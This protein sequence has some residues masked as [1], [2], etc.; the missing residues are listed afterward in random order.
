MI[1][2][3]AIG[4]INNNMQFIGLIILI[5]IIC[6]VFLYYIKISNEKHSEI[7][8]KYNTGGS[9]IRAP[10]LNTNG[11]GPELQK[12]LDYHKDTRYP[13]SNDIKVSTATL[14]PCQIHFNDDGTS[15]YIYEDGWMEF[16]T[17]ISND[18]DTGN[19]NDGVDNKGLVYNVPYKKFGQDNNNMSDF[20]NF[21][22]TTKCFKKKEPF[23][24]SLN[25]YKY[26]SNDL[27]K[28]R[29][30]TYI[31]INV[32]ENNKYD[33]KL[34]MQMNFDKKPS[35]APVG[36]YKDD[37]LNSICSYNYN[38][39]LTLGNMKL[40]R[41]TII[42]KTERNEN[43]N[44]S[45]I[46]G[47]HYITIK[48]DNNSDFIVSDDNE[49]K[50]ALPE[51][52]V[53]N[54]S[55]Y[56]INN[57][58][59]R[60][61][62]KKNQVTGDA[63]NGINVKIYKFNRNLDCNDTIRSYETSDTRFKSEDL[64]NV[65][66]YVSEI[67][68]NGNQ[69]PSDISISNVKEII[70]YDKASGRVI[71]GMS[72]EVLEKSLNLVIKES[73]DDKDSILQAIY[74][75]ICKLIAYS[76][77]QLVKDVVTLINNNGIQVAKKKSFIESFDTF[78]K[79]ISLY[80]QNVFDDVRKKQLFDEIAKTKLI[81]N[82][83]IYSYK[84]KS[85]PQIT[86]N[87]IP[88]DLENAGYDIKIYTI[89][90]ADKTFTVNENIVCDILIVAGGG[91]GGR[92]RHP[93]GRAGGGGGAG[94]L[95]YMQNH[96]LSKG[97]YTITVG[98]GGNIDVGG[99][100]RGE[101]FDGGSSSFGSFVATGGGGGG[102]TFQD[103]HYT[104]GRAGGSGGGAGAGAAEH[105][106]T[107][108]GGSGVSRQGFDG[109]GNRAGSYWGGAGAG[110]GGAGGN[111]D[112]WQNVNWNHEAGKG[113]VG[114]SINITG[115]AV[116]YA[117]GGDGGH[118][119]GANTPINGAANTGNGGDGS[120]FKPAGR[121][122][123][124][125]VIVRY[126]KT[127]RIINDVKGEFI[128][129]TKHQAVSYK[130][131]LYFK[132]FNGY[133]N[134]NLRFT[135]DSNGNGRQPD[136][137]T[138]NGINSGIV[139][140]ISNL[141]EGTNNSISAENTGGRWDSYTVEWQ[142]YF[143]AQK[144][145]TYHFH[146]ASDDASHLWIGE[147]AYT[148]ESNKLTVNNGGLHGRHGVS[149]SIYLTS[150]IYYPMRIL[151][152]ENYGHDNMSVYFHP[153]G[154]NW[155]TNGR[156]WY[157]HVQ[158]N[159]EINRDI[160]VN[161]NNANSFPKL[162]MKDKDVDVKIN[163]SSNLKLL[164][165]R[166]YIIATISNKTNI[167]SDH[168]NPIR[169]FLHSGGAENQTVHTIFFEKDTI[170]DILIVAGGGGGGM[171][172]GG[173]G[174][175]GGVIELLNY[176][177]KA[178][179]YN[180]NIGRGGKGAPAAGTSG[181]PSSHQYTI[182][183]TQGSNSSF[184]TIT[185]IG[186]GF[187]G[188]SY[189][190][191]TLGGRGGNGGSGGGTSGYFYS[192]QPDRAGKGTSGQGNNGGYSAGA[193]Y[194]AGG[195]GAGQVGGGPST[196]DGGAR[197][198]NGKESNILGTPYYWGGGGGGSSWSVSGGDGGLGGGG[199]GTG[200]YYSSRI[201]Q[202]GAGYINNGSPGGGNSRPRSGWGYASGGNGGAHT[203]GGGGGGPHYNAENKGG[204]GGSG[205]VIIKLKGESIYETAKSDNL[206]ISYDIIDENAINLKNARDNSVVIEDNEYYISPN[207]P[208]AINVYN[209]GR[210]T[211]SE[212]Y[213]K[214]F[215]VIYSLSVG[216]ITFEKGQNGGVI[217]TSD[218]E[219]KINKY[220]SASS[221]IKVSVILVLFYKNVIG[222][223][224]MRLTGYS[225]VF[226]YNT[227]SNPNKKD[228]S[229]FNISQDFSEYLAKFIQFKDSEINKIFG[230]DTY[231][232]DVQAKINNRTSVTIIENGSLQ[233]NG[234]KNDITKEKLEK[235]QI[236]YNNVKVFNA[237]SS[238]RR[239]K[240]TINSNKKI[241][242]IIPAFKTDIVS[243]E[244]PK[245]KHPLSYSSTYNIQPISNNYIYFRYPNQ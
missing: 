28:Y 42:P 56:T 117:K 165:N 15:K 72:S 85:V 137:Q 214:K 128:I 110:G 194:G 106:G 39:D 245:N 199:G 207:N 87:K 210:K 143:Y 46:S 7:I 150:G 12:T 134:D 55:Y 176:A 198:G 17:L 170:C 36:K 107:I 54:S 171:D 121:G 9:F 132:I 178:G 196:A 100:N 44:D 115:T 228:T 241:V 191:Y 174:G 97:R 160:G 227:D 169:Q 43:I 51:L 144:T 47:L 129:E 208:N 187:G 118:W 81:L 185:A 14:R 232:R 65:E 4:N 202:G 64:I 63:V 159:K 223:I 105:W 167:F 68:N 103:S 230:L 215:F 206:K 158:D 60:Y 50:I 135:K 203:G 231:N 101:G 229:N 139:T 75:F 2:K 153:P 26:K 197:G 37:V 235:L 192:Q 53:S 57:G 163:D 22:E 20:L 89:D 34:F 166:T 76:N 11:E 29:P 88:F 177:V 18:D 211:E 125:I 122:G 77:Q 21:N 157:Y 136:K 102:T 240:I 145:G 62:I 33:K 146:T 182:N 186:G 234:I 155:T 49:T 126:P 114:R 141:V 225:N 239:P 180:I 83:G 195:G 109:G 119:G 243:Y 94:G 120:Q 58:N 224:Y 80:Q 213:M 140:A 127:T 148:L 71:N 123:S 93:S 209:I 111:G 216:N 181:Q 79:Y 164:K 8:E 242:D 200:G 124:G 142:G 67:I 38:K 130:D 25:T 1:E 188:S 168:V 237:Q 233:I 172:M 5:L 113:G 61:E 69:I 59:I 212:P 16:N 90:T 6:I 112:L 220:D 66:N 221:D 179:T 23:D 31:E 156:G 108:P 244:N 238:D 217:S 3:C 161:M 184:G 10:Y 154:D 92:N 190:D 219:I 73:Y 218:Y 70:D 48:Q 98:D 151:L 40:F 13:T 82:H 147:G 175:G 193:W 138:D 32:E 104:R 133:Y 162:I 226:I 74:Y 222:D 35:N 204:D 95:I 91:A 78:T 24:D 96:I 19:V 45:L 30:D 149:G 86:F 183:A 152:G 27:I 84:F 189:Q 131:G 41:V 173:G 205:I 236:I 201:T 99:N 52:L 116:T